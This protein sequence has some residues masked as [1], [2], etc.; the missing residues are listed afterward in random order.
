V[1]GFGGLI[2][3]LRARAGL[4]QRQLAQRVGVH[5]RSIQDWEGS[6]SHPTAQR[7]R[8]LIAVYLDAG[9][10]IDG[11]EVEEAQAL[12][13]AAQAEAPGV[14]TPFDA[15]WFGGLLGTRR[16]GPAATASETGVRGP[17][18][19]HWGEAPD[20]A[21]FLGRGAERDMLRQWV[22]DDRCRIVA[23][24]GFG[25]I[26]KTQLATRL[27]QD[28]ASN[29]DFVYWRSLRN[30]P[31]PNEWL[32][33]AIGFMSSDGAPADGGVPH[34]ERL[35]ELS[36]RAACLL[37]L[38]NFDSVLQ[39]GNRA[40]GYR[41]GF[42]DY[43]RLVSELGESPNR[44]CLV[45]TSREEPPEVAQLGAELGPVRVLRLGGMDSLAVRELLDD[46]HL[47]GD[48]AAWRA[49][50]TRHASNALALKVVGET[51]REFFGGSISAY[52]ESVSASR[53][54]MFG[55]LRL[56]LDA[57]VQRLSRVEQD[58]MLWLAV[59]REAVT[60]TELVDDV[61]ASIGRGVML[62]A[63]EG[64]RR[65]S[66]LERGERGATFTLPSVVLEYVTEQMID[67]VVREL[68][69]AAP[70]RLIAQPLIKA[71]S[72][73]DVRR[74][75]ERL[76]GTPILDRLIAAS[77]TQTIAEQKLLELL[78]QM[79]EWPF[80]RQGYGPGNVVNLLRL[81]RGD[82]RG[83]NL[84]GLSIRQAYL[85][86]VEA[87][88]AN[89][90]AAEL[91]E[92]IVAEA[93]AAP[94]CVA[95]SANGAYVAVGT[96]AGEVCVWRIADRGIVLSTR[97][98]TGV[99]LN[100]A[101]TS[102]GQY[103]VSGSLD[104]TVRVWDTFGARPVATLDMPGDGVWGLALSTDGRVV[105]AGSMSGAIRL[106]SVASGTLM[107]TLRGHT[108][109]VCGV[110]LREDARLL[111]TGSQDGTFKLWELPS[112]RLNVTV[113]VQNGP[114]YSVA[115]D[116]GGRLVAT[117][118]QNGTVSVFSSTGRWLYSFQAHAGPVYGVALSEDGR[119]LAS[120]GLDGAVRIWDADTGRQQIT[121]QGHTGGVRGVSL[122]RD[123]RI[124]ATA[125]PEGQ[126]RL[127]ETGHGQ[128]LAILHG[129]TSAVTYVALSGDGQWVACGSLDGTV[130]LWD[131]P[132]GELRATLRGH[133]DLVY[134]V[135]MSRDGRLVVSG[136]YDGTVRLW[137]GPSGRPL[138]TVRSHAGLVYQVA[139]TADGRLVASGSIDGT[140]A[141]WD[142]PKG[143]P[144][145]PLRGHAGGVPA[146]ALSD[147]GSLAASGSLD[148][149]VRI[150]DTRSSQVLSRLESRI[151]LVYSVALSGDGRLVA[152][153]GQSGNINLWDLPGG[154][155]R[156][157]LRGHA[158]VV[159]GLAM[160]ADGRLL[161]SGS[162]DGLVKVWDLHSGRSVGA[163][164]GHTAGVR[165]VALSGD[166]R[167]VAS[168]SFD[169]SV[170]LWSPT[171]GVS[172]RILR[173]DR[174]YER[175]DITGLRG[176][177]EAQR[178]AL[179]AL[180]AVDSDRRA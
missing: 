74:T 134:G 177:T 25:G 139:V 132:G 138:A 81:L 30:A 103:L 49:L 171:G 178:T 32:D 112:G 31:P 69:R 99:V 106:W 52:L 33:S 126:L 172:L 91:A 159:Y 163:L 117:A 67:E 23:I 61:G 24:L 111:A 65:R 59:G 16:T 40:G 3:R 88:D 166:S 110:A 11:I 38:D 73:D 100:V 116:A 161:V 150:W 156:A 48:Q 146:V 58:L 102:D 122:S 18:R 47:E 79:R 154:Q 108:G 53:A 105:A 109:P 7:L 137:E 147:D 121:L 151:G 57:Q 6:L 17:R 93:F 170:R 75:Q 113:E 39:P 125:S 63:L 41:A 22:L 70:A 133:T 180:G 131:A 118:N 90:A 115:L 179:T 119:L 87:Q 62:E 168:G 101:L 153:G 77:G 174:R 144:R 15:A 45:L 97:E 157:T 149:T 155:P 94:N 29:F 162:D 130:R 145:P 37:V 143:Q 136:G 129:Y 34:L 80:A 8:G 78:G 54:I 175:M 66:M 120:G 96:A 12:W 124:A 19:H 104:G 35:M 13:S 128:Q 141:L 152:G 95:L 72:K 21:G 164:S 14:R 98:H 42:E 82:L 27:A 135:A 60:F 114:I 84:S 5:Q 76:I 51:I 9:A 68:S 44:S 55:S 36:Q 56:L 127:W 20:V 123:G 4:T 173:A 85:Q 86:E 43:G 160:S 83:V 167:L 176:V 46:K 92:S 148:A 28:V 158:S 64:L 142:V 89:L 1:E 2:A 71:T 169:G 10:F 107:A 140:V 50:E 165:G 26:G